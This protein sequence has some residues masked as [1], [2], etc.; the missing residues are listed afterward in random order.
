M[1]VA[2]GLNLAGYSTAR[3]ELPRAIF[4]DFIKARLIEQD[5]PQDSDGRIFYR[6][7]A[8]GRS[9]PGD[10]PCR[11][12]RKPAGYLGYATDPLA[13]KACQRASWP[14]YAAS[15]ALDTRHASRGP[16]CG[17]GRCLQALASRTRG[18]KSAGSF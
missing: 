5:R 3:I 14:L 6:L 4:D 13:P 16:Y 2:A 11:V 18:V 1:G 15:F 10:W 8:D 12:L 17:A 7:T 9:R